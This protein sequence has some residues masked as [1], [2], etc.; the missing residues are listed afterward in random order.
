MRELA[1][2]TGESEAL[3]RSGKVLV[4]ET[5]ADKPGTLFAADVVIR[6][7][8]ELPYVSRGGLK[9]QKGLHFFN[10]DPTDWICADIGASTGG[11][12][13]CLLQHG[14]ALVYAIDVAYGQLDWKLR[15]DER[16]VVYER[17]NVRTITPDQ[18]DRPLDLAVFDTSFIS[19]RTV[20]P[21]VLE[22]FGSD[23]KRLLVLVK[24][25]FEL[26][27]DTVPAGGVIR[28]RA[29]RLKAVAMIE[30]LGLREGL[31]C[32]GYTESPIKG[33]KGNVEYLMYFESKR[34]TGS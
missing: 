20:I 25:Q 32:L 22:C 8:E 15:T 5:I 10:L 26:P 14:A 19:L 16:V 33:A 7:K 17:L 23:I 27:H 2:T 9:L 1:A 11:F 4:A 28:N 12:T 13:D 30:S 21:P 31:S 6:L 29:D 18:F 3:I 24:P 34:D